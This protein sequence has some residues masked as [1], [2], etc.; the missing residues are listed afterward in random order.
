[1]CAVRQWVRLGVVALIILQL[2]TLSGRA[3][4]GQTPAAEVVAPGP[5]DPC[6]DTTCG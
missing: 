5:N 1:M 2:A 6:H 3:L 4:T